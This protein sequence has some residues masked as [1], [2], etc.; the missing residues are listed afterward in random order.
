MGRCWLVLG[1]TGAVLGG[2]GWFVV[3]VVQYVAV[4][5]GTWWYWVSIERCWLI[6]G[7]ACKGANMKQ[8][9]PINSITPELVLKSMYASCSTGPFFAD[10]YSH[11]FEKTQLK[12]RQEK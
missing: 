9:I 1:G 7:G 4:M 12:F 5:F 10:H 6:G 2:T 11:R 3:V 8:R